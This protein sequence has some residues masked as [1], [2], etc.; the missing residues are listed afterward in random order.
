MRRRDF[1]ALLG[2]AVAWPL[3]ARAQQPGGMRRIGVLVPLRR[4]AFLQQ[5]AASLAGLPRDR[6]LSRHRRDAARVLRSAGSVAGTCAA[7][8][9]HS[10]DSHETRVHHMGRPCILLDRPLTTAERQRRHRAKLREV[11]FPADVVERLNR[12]YHR[13]HIDERRAL[14]AGVKKLLARWQR[15]VEANRRYWAKR[16]PK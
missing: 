8:L 14:C 7:A 16:F 13:V 12:D 2:G 6:R 3:A 5:V 4:D 1:I 9:A 10:N 15:E 11:V